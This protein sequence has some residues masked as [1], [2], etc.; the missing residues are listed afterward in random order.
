MDYYKVYLSYYTR[1]L[2]GSPTNAKSDDTKASFAMAIAC[3][4]ARGGVNNSSTLSPLSKRDF[5]DL[6]NSSFE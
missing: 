1:I 3:Y 4:H 5:E 2:S 6:L